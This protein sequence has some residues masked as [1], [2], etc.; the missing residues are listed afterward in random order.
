[1]LPRSLLERIVGRDGRE[2][3]TRTLTLLAPLGGPSL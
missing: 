1:V 2:Q 3:V